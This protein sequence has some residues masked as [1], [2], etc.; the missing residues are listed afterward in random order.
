MHKHALVILLATAASCPAVAA[1]AGDDA[2]ITVTAT[3]TAAL[4][5]NV[6]ATVS[7]ITAEDIENNLVEDIRDLVRF[8]PGVTVRVQPARFGAAFGSTGRDG[9]SGFNIRG[10][11][12]NRVLI[13]TDGI[14]LPDGFAFGAQ[15]VGRGDY[16]DLD[17]LKSVEIL[18]GP[19]SALYGSDGLA[20]AVSFTTRDPDDLVAPG[21]NIGVRARLGYASADDAW[22]KGLALGMREGNLSALVAYSRRDSG[23]TANKGT[24]DTADVRRTTANPQDVNSDAVLAKLVWQVAPE[25]R[26][27]AT[28]EHNGRRVASDVLSARA[29]PPLGPTS[30]LR[31]LAVDTSSRNR[32][33][34]D[35]AYA[36]SGFLRSA[37]I[38]A[39][40]QDSVTRQFSAED[41]NTAADRIRDN[42]FD[43]RVTGVSGLAQGRTTT[44]TIIH[45]LLIGGDYN[46]TRQSG[47]RTG[48]VPP[49]GER[50]PTS[51]FP[52][53]DYTQAGVFV[54]D[55]IDI[56]GGRLLLYPALRLDHYK[57]EPRPDPLFPGQTA[58]KSDQ[59]LS[60]K[61]GA[62]WWAG[63]SLGLFGSY[64]QGFRSPTPSQVNNG[65]TNPLLGYASL[66][67]PDLRPETSTAFEA[68]VRLRDADLGGV[69]LNG[70]VT[71]FTGRYNDFIEQVQVSGS[72]TPTDPGIFQFIN[73]GRV[74]IRGV[75][76][77]LE[78]ALGSGF[79][80]NLAAAYA[81]GQ[82]T[83][84][85]G[86]RS[87]LSSINPF[88]IVG[89]LAWRG[90]AGR[91][92]AQL[93]VTH[94]AGKQQADIAEA[95]S[96]ACFTP[97]G[98]TI[99][100]ATAA[101]AV[102]PNATV[103]VGIFNI[104]NARYFWWNDVRGLAA[105]SPVTDAFSQPG[106]NASA[107][108]IIRY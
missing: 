79:A 33:S 63:E 61:L 4:P 90:L 108:L 91:A 42:R 43:N 98:F 88:N 44:G 77:R 38:I 94:S 62:V 37:S 30:V 80:L 101:F 105:N 65:F 31:L 59:R 15:S 96:P 107:S 18:R 72:L 71:G 28:Y 73:T 2:T 102:T 36:G 104:F 76:A 24:I 16:A 25:H 14:R 12:G 93:F 68:G 21:Q 100:D 86:V 89:G 8:E 82:A 56:G 11:D 81:D 45:D 57:L 83:N 106:R 75:E 48:T 69:T 13:Q 67:N 17:L 54:Q 52:V 40:H 10:L 46:E 39:F 74:R 3:R 78:A 7:V 32:Y 20:G 55:S 26:L 99:A 6:P 92:Q 97:P 9:N 87:P 95:C 41:R 29:V 51:A 35:W 19:A 22:N 58:T 60:P 64:A 1:E 84:A 85:A 50:F 103:R 66:P 70:S 23:A 27:R 5:S 34:L 53:T 49:P 47:I